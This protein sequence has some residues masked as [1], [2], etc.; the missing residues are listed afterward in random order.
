MTYRK[1]HRGTPQALES[2]LNTLNAHGK[3]HEVWHLGVTDSKEDIEI[4]LEIKTI[5]TPAPPNMSYKIVAG[6]RGAIDAVENNL[7]KAKKYL[8]TAH[9]QPILNDKDCAVAIIQYAN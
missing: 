5:G 4:G 3:L 7:R 2:L 8:A 1:S 9:R 6:T